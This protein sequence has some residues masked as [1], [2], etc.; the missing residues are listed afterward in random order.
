MKSFNLKKVSSVC[1]VIVMA[2]FLQGFMEGIRSQFYIDWGNQLY[3][4]KDYKGAF[5][6]YKSASELNDGSAYYR[7]YFLYSKGKGTQ[8][9]SQKAMEMLEKAANLGYTDA[10]VLLGSKL[11]FEK[12]PSRA[13]ELLE[14][15]AKKNSILALRHLS[16]AYFY[17]VGVDKNREKAQYYVNVAN[18]IGGNISLPKIKSKKEQLIEIQ[19]GLKKLGLYN[20]KIDG[21]IGP[22]MKDAVEFFLNKQEYK[23]KNITLSELLKEI[24]KTVK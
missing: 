5:E 9:D 6:K 17:G 18:K 13:I 22:K 3:S 11:I 16:L 21:V 19:Q 24:N 8:K 14:K 20:E 12:N 15:A 10:E 2:F 7:L 23:Y 1:A 4:S